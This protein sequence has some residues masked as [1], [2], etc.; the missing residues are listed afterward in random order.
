MIIQ[1]RSEIPAFDGELAEGL[2]QPVSVMDQGEF[3]AVI[4]WDNADDEDRHWVLV[5]KSDIKTFIAAVKKVA[6]E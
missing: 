6:A 2:V 3:V 4:Q 1:N 5:P